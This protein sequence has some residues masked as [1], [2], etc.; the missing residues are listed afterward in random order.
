MSDRFRF[1]TFVTEADYVLLGRQHKKSRVELRNEAR[2]RNLETLKTRMSAA[3]TKKDQQSIWA[4]F[5]EGEERELNTLLKEEVDDLRNVLISA[6]SENSA[7]NFDDLRERREASVADG[8]AGSPPDPRTFEIPALSWFARLSENRRLDHDRKVQSA[9][10]E[11]EKRLREHQTQLSTARQAFEAAKASRNASVDEFERAYLA[12]EGDAVSCYCTLALKRSVYPEAIPRN[13]RT[14]FAA[15]SSEFV[16]EA[17]LPSIDVIPPIE[18]VSWVKSKCEFKPKLRK[19]AEVH[20]LY[21]ELVAGIALR[22]LHEVFAADVAR[23]VSTVVFNGY[24]N[25]V[26]R[27]TGKEVR[28]CLISTRATRGQF[29]ELNLAKVDELLCLRNLGAQFSSKPGELVAVRPIVEF[30]MVDKRF[31]GEMD[32]MAEL[33]ERPNLMDLT[34]H[35]FEALVSNLFA[36]M[37]L[38]TKLTRSSRDG[39]VDAVAFDK[40]PVLGGKVVIQAKRYSHTVGVAAVRD[41]YGTMMNEGANKGI[42]VTT[43]GYG[44][45]AFEFAKDKPIELISGSGLLYLLDQVGHPA[46]I[47]FPQ[48]VGMGV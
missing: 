37:G 11:Y 35:E 38:E 39:G 22:H 42:L 5:G 7:I 1:A 33:N 26:D 45:D 27:A 40:R 46:R 34:P 30:D 47:M 8:T 6:L 41:L 23:R 24:V 12:G 13:L 10:A 18:S 14:I 32:V 9:M 3:Q 21:Q 16:V 43:S 2:N 36:K 25:S 31:V 48:D 4:C 17:V 44:P 15:E 28:P 20:K 29:E 19:P